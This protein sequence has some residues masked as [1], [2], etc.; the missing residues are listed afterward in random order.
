[1]KRRLAPANLANHLHR[2][3]RF[4][5]ALRGYEPLLRIGQLILLGWIAVNGAKL[6]AQALMHALGMLTGMP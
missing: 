6:L 4:G 1:M 5:S 2:P 3:L